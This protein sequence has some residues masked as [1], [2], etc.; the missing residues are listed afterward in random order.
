M[1]YQLEYDYIIVAGLMNLSAIV[2]FWV[3][4]IFVFRQILS[5]G[6]LVALNLYF[7][8]IWTPTEFFM[9]FPKTISIKLVSF[10]RVKE[11][12]DLKDEDY[13]VEG[14]QELSEFN[15]L[16]IQNMSFA[17]NGNEVLKNINLTVNKGEKILIQG[18]NGSGKTTLLKVIIRLVKR[19]SGKVLVNG[20]DTQSYTLDSIRKNIVFISQSPFLFKGHIKKYISQ[21]DPVISF[22]HKDNMNEKT[23]FERGNNLSGGEKKIIQLMRGLEINGDVY[24]L[25][26][27]LE[28]I[29]KENRQ[30]FIEQ[31][32]VL[33]KDKTLIIVSH[34]DDFNGVV[35]KVY[36]VEGSTLVRTSS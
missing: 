18:D 24:L 1:K 21:K 26:E 13:S 15:S 10:F 19:D 14:K 23:V 8:K 29:D 17:Y 22:N 32:Q 9:D 25:D 4:G 2:I 27:P 20:Y 35:D 3:G 7:S 31:I 6:S 34:Q 5:V 28:N 16:E 30:A 36:N 33:F 11:L 12:F